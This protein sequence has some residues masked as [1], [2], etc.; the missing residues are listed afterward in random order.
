MSEMAKDPVCGMQVAVDSAKWTSVHEDKRWTFCSV[1]CK[2]KF[3][4]DPAKYDGSR[5]A[6]ELVAI[7]GTNGAKAAGCCSGDSPTMP[8]K[9][10]SAQIRGTYTCPMHPEVVSERMGACPK[11]G[12]ALEPISPAMARVEY[13]C[14]MHP[15][16]VRDGPGSCPIC[17][18]ALEPREVTADQENPELKSMLLRFWAGVMLTLPLLAVMVIEMW[19]EHRFASL[20]E[21]PWMGWAQMALATPV[22]LWCGWP[23]FERG[24]SSV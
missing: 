8:A 2:K 22:V 10:S 4:A 5:V 17:G 20:M 16:I 18:M 7:G 23:F 14:P 1:G 12:M 15:E 9:S 13:T 11:C 21:S 24:W 19:P 3:E 6:E